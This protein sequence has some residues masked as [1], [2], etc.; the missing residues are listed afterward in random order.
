M[1]SA[2]TRW[3]FRE[4]I[5]NYQ[6]GIISLSEK[7]DQ[8]TFLNIFQ[9]DFGWI[10]IFWNFSNPF[11]KYLSGLL[12]ILTLGQLGPYITEFSNHSYA[13]NV[14]CSTRFCAS[15]WWTYFGRWYLLLHTANGSRKSLTDDKTKCFFLSEPKV[16][17]TS[18]AY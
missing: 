8:K 10:S 13:E 3:D 18:L 12:C 6:I 5:I 16:V 17:T 7:F 2:Y 14:S 11:T 15:D 4:I 1:T 9:D